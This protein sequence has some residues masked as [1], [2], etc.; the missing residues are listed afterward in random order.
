MLSGKYVEEIDEVIRNEGMPDW[1]QPIG[2]VDFFAYTKKGYGYLLVNKEEVANIDK[3]TFKLASFF[4]KRCREFLASLHAGYYNV[5]SLAGIVVQLESEYRSMIKIL[6]ES[7]N[8]N[9]EFDASPCME[10]FDKKGFDYEKIL[11]KKKLE[12]NKIIKKDNTKMIHNYINSN[13]TLYNLPMILKKYGLPDMYISFGYVDVLFYKKKALIITII[14]DSIEDELN[15]DGMKHFTSFINY[16]RSMHHNKIYDNI[17][18]DAHMNSI[19][20]GIKSYFKNLI[21]NKKLKAYLTQ[22]ESLMTKYVKNYHNS[23]KEFVNEKAEKEKA[24]GILNNKNPYHTV[25]TSISH[26]DA[27]PYDSLEIDLKYKLVRLKVRKTNEWRIILNLNSKSAFQSQLGNM[28]KLLYPYYMLTG[29]IITKLLLYCEKYKELKDIL[30][31]EFW[32]GNTI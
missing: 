23:I 20:D 5:Q 22:H 25:T 21:D 32:K 19:A 15:T 9:I 16:I 17:M 6:K 31:E 26:M 29:F 30:P 3:Y 27:C 1:Y 4:V 8:I 13:E 14:D 28:A 10:Y 2:F 18:T 24:S 11:V 12:F 7:N